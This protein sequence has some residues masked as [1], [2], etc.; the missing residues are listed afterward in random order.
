MVF[1]TYRKRPG[2]TQLAI[3]AS[4]S[5]SSR[6]G[7]P[8]GRLEI[9]VGHNVGPGQ[10]MQLVEASDFDLVILR[11]PASEVD[12]FAMLRSPNWSALHA[13]TLL[14]F[15]KELG[16]GETAR[17]L[18]TLRRVRGDGEQAELRR[19]AAASFHDYRSHYFANPMIDRAA[20]EE[21]YVDWAL[22]YSTDGSGAQATFLAE[23]AGP[24]E[25][26][27]FASLCF[28]PCAE[29]ALVA[30]APEYSG[31]GFYGEIL[32][33][34]E[35]YFFAEKKGT[36]YISTQVHNLAV[37]RTVTKR[38]YRPALSLQTVHLVK[39]GGTARLR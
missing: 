9:P 37:V 28:E 4:T 23:M 22:R 39:G 35:R 3:G 29:F 11:Y 6:F 17:S 36:C 1:S 33:A 14:Y 24:G 16:A 10:V 25:V 20:I 19:L 26:V 13:D 18:L 7:L 15:E 34:G 31:R 32:E 12:W 2:E 38:G 8:V 30:V 27:G 21:G 5:E